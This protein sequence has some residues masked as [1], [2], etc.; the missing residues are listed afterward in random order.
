MTQATDDHVYL[1]YH[2]GQQGFIQLAGKINYVAAVILVLLLVVVIAGAG[3]YPSPAAAGWGAFLAALAEKPFFFAALKGT[4]IVLRLMYA[5]MVPGYVMATWRLNPGAA[6]SFLI[7][8]VLSLAV[9]LPS[10]V[11]QLSL[12]PLAR[13]F[14]AAPEAAQG[15]YVG[16]AQILRTMTDSGETF[17][18]AVLFVG[19]LASWALVVRSP[20]SPHPRWH[21]WALWVLVFVMFN[22][23]MGVALF[24]LVNIVVTGVL[25]VS[26]GRLMGRFRP[27]G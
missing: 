4:L 17:A 7:F 9:V 8:T 5:V 18:N 11:F 15:V 3:V 16:I 10:Q 14:V 12:I 19:A 22:P 2:P 13:R 24:D 23:F 6:A 27:A 1:D 25:F 21:F 20:G 26:V